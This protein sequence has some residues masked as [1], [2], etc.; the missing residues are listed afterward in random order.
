MVPDYA[1]NFTQYLKNFLQF[2]STVAYLKDPPS[3]YPYPAVDLLGT[4][5]LIASNITKGVYTNWYDYEL[6]I[7][8]LIKAAYDGHLAVTL[9]LL[10]SFVFETNVQLLSFSTD[11]TSL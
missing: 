9:P 3:T 10:S 2:Q 11:G 4:L 7:A 6:E 8:F 5:D 1:S